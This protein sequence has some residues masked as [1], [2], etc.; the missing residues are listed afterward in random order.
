M[1]AKKKTTQVHFQIMI[2]KLNG[3]IVQKNSIGEGGNHLTA[4]SEITGCVTES[5]NLLSVRQQKYP[6]SE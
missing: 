4:E 5:D 1:K 3:Y 6:H 2:Q